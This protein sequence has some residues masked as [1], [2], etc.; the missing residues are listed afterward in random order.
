MDKKPSFGIALLVTYSLT[1]M[2]QKSDEKK[3]LEFGWDYP[4]SSFIEAN[5]KQMQ[6]A[7][8]DGVVFSFDAGIYNAFDTAIL[9][10]DHFD[11]AVLSKIKWQK[12]TDNF[13]FTRGASLSGAHWLEDESWNKIIKNLK[14]VS[15]ALAISKAKGVAFDPE[16][17]YKE[18]QYNPWV[19]DSHL[20]KDLSFDQ[21]GKY[22]EKRGKEFVQA[23]ETYKPDLKILCFWLLGLAYDRSLHQPL[24]QT[25][26]ALYPYF[27]EGMLEGKN[28]DVQIIDGNESSYWYQ[29]I[30]SFVNAGEFIRKKEG[31]LIKASLR[32]EYENISIAQSVYYD[33]L[34][35]VIPKFNKGFDL[36]TKERWLKDNLYFAFKTT[37]EYV[38]F[39]SE[40]IDWWRKGNAKI[41]ELITKVRN[42]IKAEHSPNVSVIKGQSF[43]PD[44]KKSGENN[45]HSFSY[46]Y[47]QSNKMLEIDL[48][49][50]NVQSLCIFQNSHLIQR[51]ENPSRY[52]KI[53][54]E[55]I[56]SEKG[57]LILIS[58]SSD[59]TI[60]VA[61][62]N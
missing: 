12:L 17:Y 15:K 1:T 27:I 8:F 34:F 57:N 61:F 22:V 37:D 21:V 16:Y 62:V 29:S 54:L 28:K 45:Y 40:R 31:S 32:S 11:Y 5:I 59:Q 51:T 30:E 24:S 60:S 50:D 13:L 55:N 9:P 52:L 33:G 42:E 19:Y 2:A 7:P 6:Q 14:K 41:A 49:R 44:F 18:A 38:W 56:Y 3:L 10:D 47:T 25:G 26:M 43:V 36:A 23:L 4:K 35:G 39:Y 20:Y 58:K 53:S 48:L 46:S